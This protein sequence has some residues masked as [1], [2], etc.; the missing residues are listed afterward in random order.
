MSNLDFTAKPLVSIVRKGKDGAEEIS[1]MMKDFRLNTPKEIAGSEVVE[2]LDFQTG[3]TI[4]FKTG[5]KG[6]TEQPKSNV[7]QFYL[8][9]GAKVTARPSGTEPKIKYYFSVNAPLNSDIRI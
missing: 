7:I 5:D 8:A 9:D 6:K 2:M 1:N 4:N 3:E